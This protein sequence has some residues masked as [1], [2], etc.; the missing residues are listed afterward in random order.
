MARQALA[1]FIK[2]MGPNHPR[3]GDMLESLGDALEGEGRTAEAGAAFNEWSAIASKGFGAENPRAVRASIRLAEWE[4]R[5]GNARSA[6]TRVE[7]NKAML[8]KNGQTDS[9]EW[10]M[11]QRAEG[12][13]KAALGDFAAA[14]TLLSSSRDLLARK[15]GASHWQTEK[16]ADALTR[17][18]HPKIRGTG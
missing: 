2:A 11:N 18:R 3:R 10:G 12:Y 7:A 13:A 8:V 15:L 17:V 14:E 16:S 9:V 5:F 4:A 1:A 6:I